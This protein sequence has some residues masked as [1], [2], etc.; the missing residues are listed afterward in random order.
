MQRQRL[1]ILLVLMSVLW[2][3]AWSR[4]IAAGAEPS[5][6][7]AFA[8]FE[9][10][11]MDLFT[12]DADGRNTQPLVPHADND[13]NASFSHDGRRIVFTSHRNASAS[14]RCDRRAQRLGFLPIARSWKRGPDRLLHTRAFASAGARR[15]SSKPSLPLRPSCRASDTEA[16]VLGLHSCLE[17]T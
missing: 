17:C 9:P 4:N 15:R 7:I 3:S 11:N 13:Y 6:T 14:S 8:S 1:K 12:D 16:L 5:Y 10:L 2:L